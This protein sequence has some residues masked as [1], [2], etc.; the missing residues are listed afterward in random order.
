MLGKQWI[1][2]YARNSG[3]CAA[4]KSR[5]RQRKLDE[6]EEWYFRFVI[7][8]LPLILQLGLLLLGCA[9]FISL[10]KVS[11]TVSL[12]ILTFTLLGVALYILF[13]LLAMFCH[14][15]PYQT[16][17]SIL[18]RAATKSNL[19][20]F[21]ASFI[22]FWSRL[23]GKFVQTLV[24]LFSGIRSGL[25]TLCRIACSPQDPEGGQL[26]HQEPADWGFGAIPDS[27]IFKR[28]GDA[29]CIS[30]ILGS[31]T[32]G[33][34]IYCTARFG[35]DTIL[36][37]DI[38]DI[39]SPGILKDHLLACLPDGR[40]PPDKLEHVNV[41]GLALASVLSIQLCINPTVLLNLSRVIRAYTDWI[42]TSSKPKFLTGIAILGVVSQSP[43]E[44]RGESF[45]IISKIPGD[46]PTNH[47]LCLSRTILQ[48][49]WR[50]RQDP[51][52]TAA[53]INLEAL[54]LF[55]K[56]LMENG[57]HI[58]PALK[59]NCFL[60]MTISLGE[61]FGKVRTLFTPNEYVILPLFP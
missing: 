21:K 56:G 38:A 24:Q 2:R 58:I 42:S 27:D 45:Q 14:S 28:G 61:Q 59:T 30:W 52:Q 44:L 54:G 17:P 39:I 32:D 53:F 26:T 1:N 37:P 41:I 46:T 20:S 49:I 13:T 57:D 11:R 22:G 40:V 3:G 36:Y 33:D 31:A 18:A 4:E 16:P 34:V 15:C 43:E 51:N 55:C 35:V 25:E 50:W 60:I 23:A 7:E 29:R 5:D 8:S 10:W 12:V 48:T 9:L 47:K 19:K 6:L